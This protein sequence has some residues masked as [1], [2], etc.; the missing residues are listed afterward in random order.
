MCFDAIRSIVRTE[1]SCLK[2]LVTSRLARVVDNPDL[3]VFVMAALS[4]TKVMAFQ[5]V[6][7][8]FSTRKRRSTERVSQPPVKDVHDIIS[9]IRA[10]A[11][12]SFDRFEVKQ[13][14]EKIKGSK[15]PIPQA[16]YLSLGVASFGR[17]VVGKLART[18]AATVGATI[19]SGEG[20]SSFCNSLAAYS[21]IDT[22]LSV[23]VCVC[24]CVCVCGL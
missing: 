19:I 9:E 22:F 8:H 16:P 3:I 12:W 10:N 21:P 13:S 6:T 24:V 18:F 4:H 11:K 23:T 20:K 17:E 5:S 7:E 15:A 2:T 14:G 1:L